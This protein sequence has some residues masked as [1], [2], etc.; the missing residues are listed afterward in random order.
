MKR[1]LIITLSIA[2]ALSA[3][4]VAGCSSGP[5]PSEVTAKALDAVKA[6]DLETLQQYYAGD[7]SDTQVGDLAG[8]VGVSE[9]DLTEEQQAQ[10]EEL[11]AMMLDFDYEL[12]DEA[13]DGDTATVEATISTRDWGTA[14]TEAIGEYL[15]N[16]FAAAFAGAGE[17]EMG[18]MAVDAFAAQVQAHS[19]KDYVTTTTFK[20]TKVDGEWKLDEFSQEN[21]D[22][23]MGGLI[24]SLQELQKNLEQLSSA[25]DTSS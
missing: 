3:L 24:S 1:M 6:Q 18:Q 2:A 20:L 4:L 5:T 19:E 16:A 17:E 8:E 13:V 21:L 11:A 9:G 22:S 15:T 7:V 23:L 25:F 14:F 12:G 10:M